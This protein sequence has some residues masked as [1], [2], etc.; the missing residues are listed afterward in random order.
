MAEEKDIHSSP[1]KAPKSQ[2]AVE[3]LSTGECWNSPEKD[4]PH[5]KPKKQP[6]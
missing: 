3:Q 1:A 5:P 6:Q 2:P 4:T